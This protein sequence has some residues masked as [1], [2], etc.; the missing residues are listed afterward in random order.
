MKLEQIK[1]NHFAFF[2]PRDLGSLY[3]QVWYKIP[4]H[5]T[6]NIHNHKAIG[7]HLC[8]WKLGH[9]NPRTH[10]G[11][12]VGKILM[13]G[14]FSILNFNNHTLNTNLS[15]ILLNLHNLFNC[16]SNPSRLRVN[17]FPYHPLH[18]LKSPINYLLNHSQIQIIKLLNKPSI[19]FRVKI[20]K[21]V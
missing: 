5:N 7:I 2:L 20:F 21:L 8:L 6:N 11:H 12:R 9:L 10:L 19:M 1:L 16:N 17:Y 15:I 13:V 3:K 4:K 18:F 14:I